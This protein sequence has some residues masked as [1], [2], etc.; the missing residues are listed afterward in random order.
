MKRIIIVG[1]TGSGKTTLAKQLSH[2]LGIPH[3]E[4]DSLYWLPNWEPSPLLEF[5]EK[6]EAVTSSDSWILDG[7]YSRIRDLVWTKADTLIW[8]DYPLWLVL[9]RSLKRG[10]RRINTQEDL[11]NSGNRETWKRFFFSRDSIL[12]WLFK[13]HPRHRQE[14]PELFKQP[15]YT[16]LNV[17]HLH[18]TQETARWLEQVK[19]N[20]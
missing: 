17:I 5:R 19:A 10:I 1:A 12:V 20:V 8:L 4:I 15:A 7:N 3:T 9:G 11:W 16:H 14:Y 2:R 13:T 6:V 18:S